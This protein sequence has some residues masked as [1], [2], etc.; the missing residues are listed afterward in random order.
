MDPTERFGDR[1]A[2]YVKYRPGYPVEIARILER[3]AGIAPARTRVLDIGS[4][5]GIS[6]E[7]FLREGYAVTGVEPNAPMRAASA[8]LLAEHA[9]FRAVDG[10]AESMPLEAGSFE[11]AIAAQAF[12]WFDAPRARGEI[13]RVLVPGGTV[14][15]LWNDR[16]VDTPFLRAYE[17]A[18]LRWGT[19][20]AKVRHQNVGED[21]IAAFFR[22]PF[23]AESVPNHQDFDLEGLLGRTTSSSYV[24]KDGQPGFAELITEVRRLFA[25]HQANGVVRVAYDSRLWFGPLR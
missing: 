14:A 5:T 25:A 22:G 13:A 9:R 21:A 1:V 18:L 24:P 8:R 15:L 4:G 11:L 20:Y 19:D 16:R 6:A 23:S 12:H 7:L 3:E 17:D 10:T 2:D